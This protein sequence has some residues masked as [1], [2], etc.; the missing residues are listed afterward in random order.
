MTQRPATDWLKDGES[1]STDGMSVEGDYYCSLII[2]ERPS[3]T[4]SLT[5]RPFKTYLV[6]YDEAAFTVSP[7]WVT[8]NV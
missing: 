5:S 6:Q 4:L 7:E 3:W 8:G 2:M 1:P